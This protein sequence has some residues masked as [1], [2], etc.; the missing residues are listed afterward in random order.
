[1]EG[2]GSPVRMVLQSFDI[3][4]GFKKFTENVTENEYNYYTFYS[5]S[6]PKVS[7]NFSCYCLPGSVIVHIVIIHIFQFLA[8]VVANL[9]GLS[10]GLSMGFSAI[11]IPQL[12]QP[13]AEISATLEQGSWIGKIFS[14]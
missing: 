8:G 3:L 7:L 6:I 2:K 11:L 14:E 5:S 4:K 1:M 10:A 9:P 12:Q 13:H